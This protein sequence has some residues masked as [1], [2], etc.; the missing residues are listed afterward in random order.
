M[1]QARAFPRGPAASTPS[2]CVYLIRLRALRA[3]LGGVL[4]LLVLGQGA[5]AT[6]VDR[7]VVDENVGGAV[8]W[9]DEAETL[10]RVEPL[11]GALRHLLSPSKTS[12]GSARGARA[13]CWL[14]AIGRKE[15]TAKR[16]DAHVSKMRAPSRSPT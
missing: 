11:H 6:H 13:S 15:S 9:G 2:D 4:H 8:V 16:R 12:S 14:P 7:R 10:I 5:V 1:R 3:L